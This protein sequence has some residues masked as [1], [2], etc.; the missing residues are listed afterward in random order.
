M[1]FKTLAGPVLLMI[2]LAL[3]A[4]ST[5]THGAQPG[6]QSS[7]SAPAMAQGSLSARTGTFEV[8]RPGESG[9]WLC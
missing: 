1:R 9:D 2:A 5:A 3:T 7:Q 8:S 6:P 4:C